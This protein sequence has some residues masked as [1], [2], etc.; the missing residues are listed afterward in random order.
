M[1]GRK[2]EQ[3]HVNATCPKF[4]SYLKDSFGPPPSSTCIILSWWNVSIQQE[5][6][7]RRG[8]NN[9]S[10]HESIIIMPGACLHTSDWV[11]NIKITNQV[12]LCIK[13]FLQ[14][15][16]LLFVI[17]SSHLFVYPVLAPISFSYF[18]THPSF[19]TWADD[20]VKIWCMA[21]MMRMTII[22]ITI[23]IMRV[24]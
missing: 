24:R 17:M 3:S 23:M 22:M 2:K 8:K 9:V 7:K 4:Q 10:M 6:K 13:Q 14:S 20:D 1:K 15:I 19:F 12:R 11:D 21:M 18:F 5:G 16:S